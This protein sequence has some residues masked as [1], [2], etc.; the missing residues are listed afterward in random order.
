MNRRRLITLLVVLFVVGGSLLF[1]RYCTDITHGGIAG[2]DANHDGI[3]DDLEKLIDE[4]W[5]SD[6]K[7]RSAARYLAKTYQDEI[8]HPDTADEKAGLFAIDCLFYVAPK[9]AY[10]IS[11]ALEEAAANTYPRVNALFRESARFNGKILHGAKS[12]E[13]A[14]AFDPALIK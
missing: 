12:R 13:E 5:G 10:D 7:I 11:K 1:L 6:P 3:R 9:Q 14:C 8:L 2:I 4:K